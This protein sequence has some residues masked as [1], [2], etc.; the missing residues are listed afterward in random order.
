[1]R[2]INI[3][4]AKEEKNRVKDLPQICPQLKDLVDTL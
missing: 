4:G 2:S 1:M 3:C